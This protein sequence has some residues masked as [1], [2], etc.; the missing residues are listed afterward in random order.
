MKQILSILIIVL[1]ANIAK[2]Q[3]TKATLQASGLT[4]SMCNLSIKKSL[5]K[6]NFIDSIIPDIETASYELFF[7]KGE[8]VNF[9]EIK[10][11]VEKAGF[12]VAQLSF[13]VN[14]KEVKDLS[15]NSFNIGI[16]TYKIIGNEKLNINS[17]IIQFYIT[18][19]DFLNEKK[20]KKFKNANS[21]GENVF[22]ITKL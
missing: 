12:S 21:V 19:K 11:A 13:S 9:L 2:A 8:I 14:L 20:Y 10:S 17:E 1:F 18:D 22:N 4:C 3:I 7:K 5:E 16:F 15:N 6:I